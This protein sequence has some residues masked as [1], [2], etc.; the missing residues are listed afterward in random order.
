MHSARI[1]QMLYDTDHAENGSAFSLP[2]REKGLS[3][4]LRKTVRGVEKELLDLAY[5]L[6]RPEKLASFSV[7]LS[8]QISLG[9]RVQ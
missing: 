2:S 9:L 3:I 1:I 6:D 8:R 4:T 5:M 7:L